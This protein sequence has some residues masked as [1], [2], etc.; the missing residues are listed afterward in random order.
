MKLLNGQHH[1]TQ[2]TC[3]SFNPSCSCIFLHR[4]FYNFNIS[5]MMTT[6]TFAT[7]DHA[8]PSGFIHVCLLFA[9]CLLVIGLCLALMAAGWGCVPPVCLGDNDRRPEW[10]CLGREQL[11]LLVREATPS[12]SHS[13]LGSVSIWG[14]SAASARRASQAKPGT[15]WECKVGWEDGSHDPLPPSLTAKTGVKKKNFHK[16][17]SWAQNY[18][19]FGSKCEMAWNSKDM[20]DASCHVLISATVQSTDAWWSKQPRPPPSE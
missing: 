6:A 15:G 10:P 18:W 5:E 9:L 11:F 20:R 2:G 12:G 8:D 17:N 3:N 7:G 1:C 19:P 4:T 13:A 14:S 16:K